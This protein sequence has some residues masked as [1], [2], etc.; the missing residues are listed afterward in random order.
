M[1]KTLIISYTP[2]ENS[3]TK[4]MLDFFI[5]NNQ[6][7]TE[8]TF[9]DLAAEA[10][11][12]LLK[13]NLNLYVNRN[14]GG[15]AL[16]EEEQSVLAK[17]DKFRDQLLA[18]DFVVLASPM[19]NFSVPATIKAWFDAVIQSGKT[20]TYTETGIKGLCENTKALILMTSGSD[21]EI[22]PYKSVNFATPFLLTAFDFMGITAEAINKFGMIQ[23]AD[24][25]EQM[26]EEAKENIR[27][28]SDKWYV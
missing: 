25:S 12:L 5:E 9:V 28:I 7:K 15:V 26:I 23:Y 24:K 2:R 10:P 4:R 1:K 3:N 19:F 22:E 13:E 27:T 11:D 20:F 18:T 8:I 17:N 14:F 16:T 21:F 6:D